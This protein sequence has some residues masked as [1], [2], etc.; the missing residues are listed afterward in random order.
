MR[1]PCP[2]EDL[3][4][5]WLDDELGGVERDGVAAHVE[6][7]RACADELEG[8]R[9]VRAQLR[10]LPER[11]MPSGLLDDVAALP[12]RARAGA[13]IVAATGVLLVATVAALRGEPP[14][15]PRSVD[16][17]VVHFVAD[18]LTDTAGE[19]ASAPDG[20]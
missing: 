15:P 5:A 13:V 10:S 11:R 17:P 2:Q 8:L 16:V 14:S 6:A 7:C 12:R 20:P 4:S 1:R 9:I 3:L 18:H 19:R